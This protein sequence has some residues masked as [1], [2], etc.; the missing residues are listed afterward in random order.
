MRQD[1]YI[2]TAEVVRV[3]TEVQNQSRSLMAATETEAQEA[4]ETRADDNKFGAAGGTVRLY[5][6]KRLE[7]DFDQNIQAR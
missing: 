4:A 2:D 6:N 1:P 5:V 3:E 7:R